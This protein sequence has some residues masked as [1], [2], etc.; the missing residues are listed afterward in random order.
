M[1]TYSTVLLCGPVFITRGRGGG[2]LCSACTSQSAWT[3]LD[4]RGPSTIPSACHS[5][6]VATWASAAVHHTQM[7][8]SGAGIEMTRTPFLMPDTSCRAAIASPAV[9]HTARIATGFGA[10]EPSRHRDRARRHRR[11]RHHVHL[12]RRRGPAATYRSVDA[13][14]I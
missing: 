14:L 4:P 2:T 9:D 10:K 5:T 11:H 1:I 6:L 8:R 7:G 13:L 12:S 3:S